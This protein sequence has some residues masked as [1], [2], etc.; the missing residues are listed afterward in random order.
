MKKANNSGMVGYW[1]AENE[2]GGGIMTDCV[3][4]LVTYGFNSLSL[5]RIYIHCAEGNKKSRAIPER[6]GFTLEGVF[7]DGECLYGEYF[8]LT[9]YAMLKRNWKH[10]KVILMELATPTMEH[11]EAAWEY[12]QEHIDY[13]ETHIHG[14]GGFIHT[15]NY[16]N[17]LEKISWNQTQSTP[18][19]VTSN[20]YFAFVDGKIVGTIAVRHALNESLMNNGGHIGYGIRPSERRKGYGA[21]MLALALYKCRE[22]GI[23]KALVTCDKDNIASAK[24]VMRNGGILEN[25]ITEDDGNIVQRYW[26]SL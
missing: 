1:L 22:F 12:R 7:G 23:E 2:Q 25:E 16:D 13:G 14:S 26:I 20:V 3:R 21:K 6:L 10:E 9:V 18:E 15:D 17:W 24:T 5:N 8:D 4:C 19:K 11:K